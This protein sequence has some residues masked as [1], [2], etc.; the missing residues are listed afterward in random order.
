VTDSAHTASPLG[1]KA[2]AGAAGHVLVGR[3]AERLQLANQLASARQGS[4]QALVVL[5]EAGIGKSALLDDLAEQAD[6]FTVCRAL[7]V[8]SEMELS[9]AGLQQLCAP[10]LGYRDQLHPTQRGALD[11]IFG[12]ATGSLPDRFLVGTAA[13]ALVESAAT[14]RP[15]LWIIDDPQWLDQSSVHTIGFVARRLTSQHVAIDIA[16]REHLDGDELTGLPELHLSGLSD[17]AAEMLIPLLSSPS[18]PTVRDRILAEARGNPLALLE[19]PRTWTPAEV[20]EEF[21]DPE[22]RTLTDKLDF[23]FTERFRDLPADTQRLLALAAAEPTGSLALFTRAAR[24]LGLDPSEAAPAEREGLI[25]IGGHVRFRHPLVRAVSYRGAPVSARLDAHR[26]LAEV[27]DPIR[28]PDR[29]AWHRA[30]S[31]LGR[32]EDIAKELEQSAGRAKARGGLLGAA[33]LLERAALL[34]PDGPRRAD[35]AVA[36]AQAKYEAGAIDSALHLLSAV[37]AEPA[38]GLREALIQRL[39]GKIALEHGLGVESAELLR[40]A[41]ARLEAFDPRLAAD[42]HFESL[43]SAIW[44]SGP[45]GP[46]LIRRSAEAVRSAPR[47]ETRC[48]ADLVANAIAIWATEGHAAAAGPIR[49]ALSTA[50]D[51]ATRRQEVDIPVWPVVNRTAGILALEAWDFESGLELA[52]AEVAIHRESGALV[53]LLFSLL[54]LG[55]Y[56]SLT[57]DFARAVSLME[58]VQQ[59]MVATRVWDGGHTEALLPAMRGDSRRALAMLETLREAGLE[60]RQGR[61]VAFANYVSSVQHN[62]LTQ[63]DQALECAKL[64]MDWRV[65]GYQTLAA[66]ELAEAASRQGD[67]DTLA[68]VASWTSDR[69]TATP[70]DWAVGI[71]ALVNAL[72]SDTPKEA[73]RLFRTSIAQLQRTPLRLA[74]ARAELLYGEWLRRRGR[75]AD[76]LEQLSAAHEALTGM[77]LQSFADRASREMAAT[78]KRNVRRYLDDPTT[79]LTVQEQQVARLAQGGLTNR[80]IGGRLYL[81]ARTVEWHLRNVFGKVGVT[82]RQQLRDRDLT[83]YMPR[84][85]DQDDAPE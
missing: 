31:T 52:Q 44:A 56:L 21:R 61:L 80:E 18:D 38:S 58:E 30:G 20:D 73:D 49:T 37:E 50:V 77:G 76:A 40:G 55:N 28:D 45:D 84:E 64:V 39:R 2:F 48:T 10:I 75:K 22:R 34:T 63:H 33:A 9:Y 23:A 74:V 62:A 51:Q 5:G 26:A 47:R 46:E 85:P 83:A 69:A 12:L 71:A 79:R 36:A 67:S 60:G 11:K 7:G 81:S 59:L 72:A 43:V 25:E 16:T 70:T 29:R 78:R 27:T 35:R 14:R 19:L 13:L 68:D 57:G 8:E 17:E 66:P 4:G 3:D 24:V 42:T 82:T 54:F 1:H 53:E 32:D 41:A 6:D 15:V 65:F